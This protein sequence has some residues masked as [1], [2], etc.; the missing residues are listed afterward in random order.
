MLLCFQESSTMRLSLTQIQPNPR[1]QVFQGPRHLSVAHATRHCLA[2]VSPSWGG[3]SFHGV[4]HGN[5]DA[6]CMFCMFCIASDNSQVSRKTENAAWIMYPLPI[7]LRSCR[8][9]VCID[10]RSTF[11]SP[12]HQMSHLSSGP[13]QTYPIAGS[14][15]GYFP[16]NRDINTANQRINHHRKS[17]KS[18][19]DSQRSQETKN[20][21][22]VQRAWYLHQTTSQLLAGCGC[23]FMLTKMTSVRSETRYSNKT[24]T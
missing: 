16:A 10:A 18:I 20:K 6:S 22:E 1:P 19:R 15:K 2:Q 5:Q 3:F 11:T 8:L 21:L 17:C 12:C 13:H 24:T 14:C 23:F 7:H 9:C 4:L